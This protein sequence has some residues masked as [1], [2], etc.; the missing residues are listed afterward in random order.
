MGQAH[1]RVRSALWRCRVY[2]TGGPHPS[3]TGTAVRCHRDAESLV[4]LEELAAPVCA[5]HL[6]DRWTLFPQDQWVYAVD[7][8]TVG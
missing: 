2:E 7:E 8:G 1:G 3:Q 4:V 5:Y 6:A